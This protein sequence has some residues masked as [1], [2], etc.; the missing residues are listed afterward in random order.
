MEMTRLNNKN[1]KTDIKANINTAC[2]KNNIQVITH[3]SNKFRR[4]QSNILL[5]EMQQGKSNC[6]VKTLIMSPVL[7]LHLSPDF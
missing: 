4:I 2:K 5:R 1:I 3:L 7:K 6:S